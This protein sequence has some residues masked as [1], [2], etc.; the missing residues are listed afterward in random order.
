MRVSARVQYDTK[1]IQIFRSANLGSTSN[2]WPSE[3]PQ[4]ARVAVVCLQRS[5]QCCVSKPGLP[6]CDSRIQRDSRSISQW[7]HG[8]SSV[9]ATVKF[10]YDFN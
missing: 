7:I 5:G 4:N 8:Y 2:C 9:I 6:K 3:W 10:T 1:K